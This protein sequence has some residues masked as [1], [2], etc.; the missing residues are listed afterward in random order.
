M[1]GDRV[2]FV[3]AKGGDH[4]VPALDRHVEQL[5][6]ARDLIVSRRGKKQVAAASG[7]ARGRGKCV[8]HTI[9]TRLERRILRVF[10]QVVAG[11]FERSQIDTA[12]LFG[13]V[14]QGRHCD[15]T[16]DV[17]S[18]R[19][20]RIRDLDVPVGNRGYR[21]I[22]FGCALLRAAHQRHSGQTDKL[23]SVHESLLCG[24][25][26][27]RFLVAL[28]ASARSIAMSALKRPA[29]AHRARR[30]V[31][32]M[33]ASASL[34]INSATA[35]G[36]SSPFI[37]NAFCFLPMKKLVEVARVARCTAPRFDSSADAG[38]NFERAKE[39]PDVAPP[40]LDIDLGLAASRSDFLLLSRL[41]LRH[42]HRQIQSP[43][44][45][46]HL[47]RSAVPD[48]KRSRLQSAHT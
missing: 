12:V 47:A 27:P 22:G 13:P 45:R 17:D 18:R 36:R 34:Y 25:S 48:P 3:R 8:H 40:N 39:N 31:T 16:T 28:R 35:P 26:T 21:V 9:Y 23:P 29:P 4:V 38:W 19:P 10:S 24:T 2:A 11:S 20:E 43:K 14:K 37:R 44:H 32:L 7:T 15:R 30:D 41:R 5:P 1:A 42:R 46:H 33:F 6:A